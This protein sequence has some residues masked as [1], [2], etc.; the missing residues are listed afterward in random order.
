MFNL[1]SA[2][3]VFASLAIFACVPKATSIPVSQKLSHTV[4]TIAI[5]P[6]GGLLAE[7]IVVELSGLGYNIID[8][9]STSG[10]LARLKLGE[11]DA[12]TPQGLSKLKEEGVDAYL[13]IK[14]ER[15]ANGLI[16]TAVARASSTHTGKI[17]AGINWQNS[18]TGLAAG[19]GGKT[20][21]KGMAETAQEIAKDLA[22]ELPQ[23]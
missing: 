14:G 16:E 8:P 4:E 20:A 18:R 5:A 9:A 13:T 21:N 2:F 15:R 23:Q 11:A 7:A 17:I 10:I 22:R 6:G 12:T 19:L 1:K 3:V